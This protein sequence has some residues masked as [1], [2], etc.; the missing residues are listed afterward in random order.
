MFDV[1]NRFFIFVWL[2]RFLILFVQTLGACTRGCRPSA[3]TLQKG[4]SA[5]TNNTDILSH[6]QLYIKGWK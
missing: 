1:Y 5:K 4:V 2:Q 3:D 6:T